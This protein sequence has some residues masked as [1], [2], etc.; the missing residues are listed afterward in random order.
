MSKPRQPREYASSP[1]MLHEF[2]N[3]DSSGD[4]VTIYH[5]PACSKSRETL[6]LIRERGI[7]PRIVE[8]LKTP[9]TREVLRA[10]TQRLKVS[11]QDLVRR[12][13]AEFKEHFAGKELNEDGWLQALAEHPRLLQ[14]PIVVRGQQAV[15]GRP[16]ANVLSLL[17]APNTP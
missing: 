11:A 16:P 7:E 8:Y 15:L 5:N 1:C 10:L 9:P 12:E 14:R 13:E 2:E 17:K 6:A 4:H 3:L